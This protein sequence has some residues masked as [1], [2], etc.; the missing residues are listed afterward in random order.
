MEDIA[1]P[2]FRCASGQLPIG[3]DNTL[4]LDTMTWRMEDGI[5]YSSRHAGTSRQMGAVLI[6]A[7]MEAKP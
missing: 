2:D 3:M 4:A 6:T 5:G 1:I 7:T